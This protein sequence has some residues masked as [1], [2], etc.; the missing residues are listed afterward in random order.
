MAAGSQFHPPSGHC[1]AIRGSGQ[2]ADPRVGG[3]AEPAAGGQGVSLDGG[4]GAGE[5]ADARD[6][7]ARAG[8]PGEDVTGSRD[9]ARLARGMASSA[10]ETSP[11]VRAGPLAVWVDAEPSVGLL[12][13]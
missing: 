6:A 9:R 3:Q 13:G 4:V 5:P 10:R 2:G 12:A 11:P 1:Q 7:A 8:Q